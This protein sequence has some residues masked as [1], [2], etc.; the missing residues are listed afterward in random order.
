MKINHTAGLLV[1]PSQTADM[2]PKLPAIS[3]SNLDALWK[4]IVNFERRAASGATLSPQELLSVQVQ[5]SR[6]SMCVELAAKAGDSAAATLR[7]LQSGA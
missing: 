3:G 5:V 7:K 1:S 4:S 2:S 6:F